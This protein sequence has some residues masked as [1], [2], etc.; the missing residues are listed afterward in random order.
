MRHSKHNTTN[1]S[2]TSDKHETQKQCT[3]YNHL[4]HEIVGLLNQVKTSRS[5][6]NVEVKQLS[7]Q[8]MSMCSQ[9]RSATT[10]MT[11][12]SSQT[13]SPVS[14]YNKPSI[15]TIDSSYLN[16]YP[17]MSP[18]PTSAT[19]PSSIRSRST[20]P[21]KFHGLTINTRSFSAPSRRRVALFRESLRQDDTCLLTGHPRGLNNCFETT[22]DTEQPPQPSTALIIHDSSSIYS[23]NASD[24][25]DASD[26]SNSE[27]SHHQTQGP[28]KFRS[29][30]QEISES[31]VLV[32]P[33]AVR[34]Q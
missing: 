13:R 21:N 28:S 29:V 15:V 23:F 33:R 30:I 16:E 7:V 11:S 5:I 6:Q 20:T 19:T 25:S 2:N 1:M 32:T 24:A 34:P 22:G 9:P 27:L 10:S 4:R 31:G 12:E 26:G 18:S 3:S 14:L 17:S 8:T